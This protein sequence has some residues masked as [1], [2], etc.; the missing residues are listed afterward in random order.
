MQVDTMNL[1]HK[2]NR[3]IKKLTQNL[4]QIFPKSTDEIHTTLKSN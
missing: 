2:T 3:R 1:I 4:A